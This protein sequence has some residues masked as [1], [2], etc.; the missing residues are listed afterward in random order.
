MIE[1]GFTYTEQDKYDKVNEYI[2]KNLTKKTQKELKTLID[3]LINEILFNGD[4]EE[5]G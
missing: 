3:D 5:R 4:G 1:Y 2:E